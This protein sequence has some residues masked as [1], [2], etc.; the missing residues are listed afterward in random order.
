MM[1]IQV[2][3]RG[4]S[5]YGWDALKELWDRCKVKIM[6]TDEVDTGEE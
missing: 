1:K 5:M 2:R 3:G 4:I 6:E